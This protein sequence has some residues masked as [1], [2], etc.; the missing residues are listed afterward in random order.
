MLYI[1]YYI[2]VILIVNCDTDIDCDYN[3][4]YEKLNLEVKSLR[5]WFNLAN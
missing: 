4:Y 3:Y 5:F 1:C 2:I